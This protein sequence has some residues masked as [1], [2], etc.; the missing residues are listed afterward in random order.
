MFKPPSY[1]P[2]PLMEQLNKQFFLRGHPNA[3]A[4]ADFGEGP[5]LTYRK[6]HSHIDVLSVCLT[7]GGKRIELSHLS[8]PPYFIALAQEKTDSPILTVIYRDAP[9]AVLE[10]GVDAHLIGQ[11]LAYGRSMSSG[12][13]TLVH[14]VYSPAHSDVFALCEQKNSLFLER[15]PE[16]CSHLLLCGSMVDALLRRDREVVGRES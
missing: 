10:Q 13:R 15:H 16:V 5:I 8:K 3:F 14:A 9:D 11:V 12:S 2:T 7:S 4:I 6:T 1:N